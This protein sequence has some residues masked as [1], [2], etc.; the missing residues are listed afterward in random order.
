[1]ANEKKFQGQRQFQNER[2]FQQDSNEDDVE[3][4]IWNPSPQG[5]VAFQVRDAQQATRNIAMVLGLSR[6]LSTK[7]LKECLLHSTD[8]IE[9]VL[10]AS[11][12]NGSLLEE[13][14]RYCLA[15]RLV[16]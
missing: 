9:R 7:E 8:C 14:G 4:E 6:P 10:S 1:M 15:P 5:F 16:K 3:N 12:K 13:K 2:Q 11:V